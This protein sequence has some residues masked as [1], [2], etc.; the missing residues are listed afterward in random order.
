M[1]FLNNH[2]SPELTTVLKIVLFK[3]LWRYIGNK[4]F[5]C[6]NVYFIK[7]CCFVQLLVWLNMEEE[8]IIFLENLATSSN[9]Q[10]TQNL[11]FSFQIPVLQWN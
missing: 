2:G 1:N 11:G 5:R 7:A 8:Q 3:H 4:K 10:K 6:L 9:F